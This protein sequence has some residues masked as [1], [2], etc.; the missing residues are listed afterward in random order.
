MTYV[1][2]LTARVA[3]RVFK[4]RA[5]ERMF[6]LILTFWETDSRKQQVDVWFAPRTPRPRDSTRGMPH[7]FPL[8]KMESRVGSLLIQV[9]QDWDALTLGH[10]RMLY[11]TLPDVDLFTML[12]LLVEEEIIKMEIAFDISDTF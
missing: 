10:A 7:T 4:P 11:R 12:R 2:L 3:F 6:D 8:E 1:P 5:T 9:L